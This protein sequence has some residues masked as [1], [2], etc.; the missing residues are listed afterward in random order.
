MRA[1]H[2]R[3]HLLMLMVTVSWACNI[4]AGKEA[5]TGFGGLALAQLRVLGAAETTA[6]EMA[7]R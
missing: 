3:M 6:A 5:L 4:I 2:S 1:R 7:G